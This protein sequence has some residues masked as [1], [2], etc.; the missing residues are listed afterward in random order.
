MIT[1][2]YTMGRGEAWFAPFSDPVAKT[3]TEGGGFR[4]LGNVP[5]FNLSIA[6]DTYQH[7]KSTRGIREKDLT[8]TLQANRTATI[9]AEDISADNIALFFMGTTATVSQSASTGNSE[10]FGSVVPGNKYQVGI[11]ATNPTG[12]RGLLNPVLKAGTTTLVAG[13]DYVIDPVRGTFDVLIGGA[14]PSTGSSVTL[15]YDLSATSRV[16]SISGASTVSGAL[17]FVSYNAVGDNVDYF[18]PYVTISPNGS[19]ALIA[20]TLQA[21]PLTIGVQ[22]LGNQAALYADGQ[23]VAGV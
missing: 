2:N 13:T 10:T 8:V 20:D 6:A 3:L 14:V 23:P 11:S 22:V 5:S 4:F 12:L 19:F 16:Q 21:L 1:D 17:K 7:Y 9:T 18:M 15:T